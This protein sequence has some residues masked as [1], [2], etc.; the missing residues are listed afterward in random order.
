MIIPLENRL[1]SLERYLSDSNLIRE[2]AATRLLSHDISL[3][4]FAEEAAE[5]NGD[6]ALLTPQEAEWQSIID[7]LDI[8]WDGLFSEEAQAFEEKLSG[9]HADALGVGVNPDEAPESGREEVLDGLRKH[10]SFYDDSYLVKT[11][12]I[13]KSAALREYVRGQMLKNTF[14]ELEKNAYMWDEFARNNFD[15]ELIYNFIKNAAWY[16]DV[17][18]GLGN[19]WNATTDA[20]SDAANWVANKARAGW[21][22]AKRWG[23]RLL[24]IMPIIGLLMSIR[25]YKEFSEGKRESAKALM[26]ELPLGKYGLSFSDV[27]DIRNINQYYDK[28]KNLAD[29]HRESSEDIFELAKIFKYSKA[30]QLNVLLYYSNLIFLI[31]DIL[32]VVGIVLT[33]TTV[34]LALSDSPVPGPMDVIA[35][36]WA[37]AGSGTLI[38]GFGWLL[39]LPVTIGMLGIVAAEFGGKAAADKVYFN[40]T[41]AAIRGIAVEELEK[42]KEGGAQAGTEEAA[43]TEEEMRSVLG[44]ED[45]AVAAKPPPSQARSFLEEHGSM[46]PSPMSHLPPSS[47]E[48]TIISLDDFLAGAQI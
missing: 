13:N 43:P 31:L 5:A 34:A 36:I 1:K 47:S 19:A 3:T 18:S 22:G 8:P 40:E 2:S 38:Y 30:Y 14:I 6:E 25:F 44:L 21:A 9:L 12:A 46:S 7:F 45:D 29:E 20:A 17:A 26:E 39:S 41:E 48:G 10:A 28:L 15:E 16:D 33:G 42:L 11:S 23:G 32:L 24:R 37:A 4:K 27:E 35:A